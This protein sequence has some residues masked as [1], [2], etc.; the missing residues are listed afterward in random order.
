[1]RRVIFNCDQCKTEVTHKVVFEATDLNVHEKECYCVACATT[2]FGEWADRKLKANG[3][4]TL[5]LTAS[6]VKSK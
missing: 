3:A 1:M 2:L 4:D 6:M 5:I